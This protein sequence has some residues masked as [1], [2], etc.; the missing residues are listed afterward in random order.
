MGHVEGWDVAASKEGDCR[1]DAVVDA[2]FDGAREDTVWLSR[3]R[4]REVMMTCG[5]R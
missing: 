2:G 1:P 4:R 3:V 5:T